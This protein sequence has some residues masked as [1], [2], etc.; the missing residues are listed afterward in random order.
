M[1]GLEGPVTVE[2]R[3]LAKA[4]V[5]VGAGA[6]LLILTSMLV[7]LE[8]QRR[9]ISSQDR[10]ITRLLASSD[11][12]LR[13]SRPLLDELGPLIDEAAPLVRETR[14]LVRSS[15]DLVGPARRA[16]LATDAFIGQL[17]PLLSELTPRDIRAIGNSISVAAR[18][19]LPLI[20]ELPLALEPIASLTRSLDEN[21]R[22]VRL[23]DSSASLVRDLS[24]PRLQRL[25]SIAL[26][27]VP[28]LASLQRILLNVQLRT[29]QVQLS[30]REIQQD[31]LETQRDSLRKQDRALEI[32]RRSLEVQKETLERIRRIEDRLSVLPSP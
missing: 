12:V 25:G 6:V 9:H 5:A 1:S 11:P 3:P 28:E 19:A 26:S 18:T 32:L 7:L 20:E 29:L 21:D 10:K 8:V 31:S 23:I 14:P 17:Q 30:S 16:A 2:F 27:T 13:R 22:F 24:Q 4:L 15:R